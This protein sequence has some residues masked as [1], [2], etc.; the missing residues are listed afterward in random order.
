MAS[1][2]GPGPPKVGCDESPSPSAGCPGHR[3]GLSKL[4]F[5]PPPAGTGDPGGG[6]PCQPRD[7]QLAPGTQQHLGSGG[8]AACSHRR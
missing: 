4:R 8:S 5:L 2:Q 3:G 6:R 1:G 7:G